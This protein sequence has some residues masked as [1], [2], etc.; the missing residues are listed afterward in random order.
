MF[1]K[2]Y[3]CLSFIHVSFIH[4]MSFLFVL[5]TL[6]TEPTK[7]N[8]SSEI[9]TMVFLCL[10]N[11]VPVTIGTQ[12]TCWMNYEWTNEN[13][14]NQPSL[15]IP[16]FGNQARTKLGKCAGMKAASKQELKPES[17]TRSTWKQKMPQ[18]AYHDFCFWKLILLLL[19]DSL[20]CLPLCI[21]SRKKHP[22]RVM[23]FGPI[24]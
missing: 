20:Q 10:L 23:Y 16:Q 24:F 21:S 13:S 19:L 6:L 1:A 17:V 11:T 4:L 14:N 12:M 9:F 5:Y 3:S 2:F 8:G 15:A 7:E 18:R 22:T